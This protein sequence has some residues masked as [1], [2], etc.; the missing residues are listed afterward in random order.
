MDGS[1]LISEPKKKKENVNKTS[2]RV[3]S[4]R[5]D[6]FLMEVLPIPTSSLPHKQNYIP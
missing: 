6:F 3:F 1:Y 4:E 5:S 2:T